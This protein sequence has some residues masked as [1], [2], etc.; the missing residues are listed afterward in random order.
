MNRKQ[1]FTITIYTENNMGLINRIALLFFKK[2]INITKINAG[3][4]DVAEVQQFTIVVT[5]TEE[6]I[7]NMIHQIEKQVDVLR[8]YYNADNESDKYETV[9]Y[10][11]PTRVIVSQQKVERLLHFYEANIVVRCNDYTVFEVTDQK[12][13]INELEE[14]LEPWGLESF[15]R[16]TGEKRLKVNIE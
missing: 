6:N 16:C 5:E 14:A 11:V 10:K 13:K 12:S 7:Q 9:V 8:A 2:R 1:E 3:P 4:T 15:V